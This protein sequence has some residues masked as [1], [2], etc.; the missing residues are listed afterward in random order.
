[1]NSDATFGT[2]MKVGRLSICL[3]CISTFFFCS[4]LYIFVPILPVYAKSVPGGTEFT[5]GLMLG[6]YSLAL[7][8]LRIPLGVWSDSIGVR[9]PFIVAGL[10]ATGVG[11]LGLALASNIWFLAVARLVTGVG[12][13]TWVVFTVLFSGYFPPE[14]VTQAMGLLVFLMGLSQVVA[15]YAGGHLA[16]NYGLE[17]VFYAAAALAFLGIL[18]MIRVVDVPSATTQK[19]SLASLRKV[20]ATPLLLEVSAAAAIILLVIFT[21]SLGFLPIYADSLGASK[22]EL[23]LLSTVMFASYTLASLSTT[24]LTPRW[25]PRLTV[26]SGALLATLGSLAIPWME[27]VSLLMVAQVLIGAGWG[28]TFP[29]LMGLSIREV[30]APERATA[31]GIFQALYGVG[32]LIGP[33]LGGVCAGL[34]SLDSVFF[35]SSGICFISVILALLKVPPR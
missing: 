1:M 29:V 3:F 27:D 21:V 18:C 11:A 5:V 23:G 25:G 26:V 28:M 2:N 4:S 9:K 17:V 14:R 33:P 31:M 35:I 30:A 24:L 32:M 7:V 15:T 16:E 22:T 19:F 6:S 10:I 8:L 13:T 12:V 20:A 34:W